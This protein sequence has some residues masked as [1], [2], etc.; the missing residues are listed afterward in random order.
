MCFLDSSVLTEKGETRECEQDSEPLESRK[1]Q[2]GD[3]A[4]IPVTSPN[5]ESVI[6]FFLVIQFFSYLFFYSCGFIFNTL[7]NVLYE[8]DRLGLY[9][10]L[11]LF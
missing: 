11:F 2:C 6:F 4:S 7:F 5:S 10:L 1:R 8:F 3:A 9:V